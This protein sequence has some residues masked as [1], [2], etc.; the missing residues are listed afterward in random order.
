MGDDEDG[1]EK[2]SSTRM[3]FKKSARHTYKVTY[4]HSNTSWYFRRLTSGIT[5]DEIDQITTNTN[6]F[7]YFEND[8]SGYSNSSGQV[9]PLPNG[10]S[11]Y[12]VCYGTGENF[13]SGTGGSN[14]AL[15][16][17]VSLPSDPVD[18]CRV[19]LYSS[20]HRQSSSAVQCLS[21]NFPGPISG[22]PGTRR[23]VAA[24]TANLASKSGGT[25]VTSPSSNDHSKNHTYLYSETDDL[26]TLMVDMN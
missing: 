16:V 5:D 19:V 23:L 11:V 22:I 24:G 17:N 26:W 7:Q 3:D 1:I 21:V 25:K 20:M 18:G 8:E 9:F 12:Y 14:V 15:G 4:R 13:G 2:V 10:K 6:H